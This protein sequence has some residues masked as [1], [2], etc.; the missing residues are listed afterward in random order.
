MG[1]IYQVKYYSAIKKQ[2]KNAICTNMGG[3]RDYCTKQSKS[4][5]GNTDTIWYHLYEESKV[6]QMNLSMKQK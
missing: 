4:E 5:R 6:T 1:Y 2:W 3:P